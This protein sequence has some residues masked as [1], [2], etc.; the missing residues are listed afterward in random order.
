MQISFSGARNA[1]LFQ[2]CSSISRAS[3]MSS[4]EEGLTSLYFS[5]R[6]D[7]AF[8]KIDQNHPLLSRVSCFSPWCYFTVKPAKPN[9][10]MSARYTL[11]PSSLPWQFRNAISEYGAASSTTGSIAVSAKKF[12]K[13][14]EREFL[15][16]LHCIYNAGCPYTYAGNFSPDNHWI[17]S[18]Y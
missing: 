13:P 16:F 17:C 9:G 7:D 10:E 11:F 3:I 12:H 4:I 1:P 18:A 5:D 15:S 6:F 2:F 14:T 8:S